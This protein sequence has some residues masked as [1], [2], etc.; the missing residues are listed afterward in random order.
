M[1]RSKDL[2]KILRNIYPELFPSLG[3]GRETP[4]LLGPSD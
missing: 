4:T 1:L 2:D 3:V